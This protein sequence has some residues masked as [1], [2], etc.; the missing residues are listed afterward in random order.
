LRALKRRGAL[1]IEC[2]QLSR[3][4]AEEL[5]TP[6]A[7]ETLA[8]AVHH[9][10]TVVR[11]IEGPEAARALFIEC[12]QLSRGLAEELK[13]PSARRNLAYAVHHLAT[14]VREIEGPEAARAL[15]FECEQ[16]MRGLAEE[17]KTPSARETLAD[18]VHHLATVV[19]EIEGPE[20]ARALFIECEQLSRGLAEEQGTASARENLARAVGHLA[21][22]VR[23]VEG[24]EAARALFVENEQ[25]MR[26]LAEE[27]KTPSARETL[28]NAVYHLATVVRDIE[29]P[30]AARALFIENEQLMRGLAEELKTPSARNNLAYAVYHLATV[31]RDI[32]GPEAAAPR[33][34]DSLCVLKTISNEG[35]NTPSKRYSLARSALIE[36]QEKQ[37]LDNGWLGAFTAE[38]IDENI[39]LRI[40]GALPDHVRDIAAYVSV[41]K[42]NHM[43][44]HWLG[45]ARL[46]LA[47]SHMRD[48]DYLAA[49]EVVLWS[50][51]D[52]SPRQKSLNQMQLGELVKAYWLDARIHAAL[53]KNEDAKARFEMAQ[54][55][56][57]KM[58]DSYWDFGAQRALVCWF[59]AAFLRDIGEHKD[60]DA[61]YQQGWDAAKAFAKFGLRDSAA[62]L[63]AFEQGEL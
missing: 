60:A 33:F 44:H 21:T 36:A 26:G 8:D 31:V 10:A 20:A 45:K 18:A 16:L 19:R 29:G 54:Q 41:H 48:A 28:A 13:T 61:V 11:E 38:L 49:K 42:S 34:E 27:L 59:H 3:G 57:D 12:E 58:H 24:P 15:F 7:R 62:I 56:L 37:L 52:L 5:K 43:A 25:L 14:V 40:V 63:Q 47:Q 50:I 1:F 4:L 32:E 6:S 53:G 35:A 22:V 51:Q 30:E 2:E 55:T 17:L 23:E 46:S 39:P 9:L